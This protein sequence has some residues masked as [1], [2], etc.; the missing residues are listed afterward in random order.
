M[1]D[2]TRL[3][4]FLSRLWVQDVHEPPVNETW[5]EMIARIRGGGNQRVSRETY[6]YFL[7]VLPPHYYGGDYFAFCEGAEA[8]KLFARRGSAFVAR[9]LT[10]QETV[11]F[12]DL[13]GI[14]LP[15]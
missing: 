15:D 10:W 4:E 2:E 1:R 3:N 8:L 14:D 5:R 9:Q 6:L 7:E 12:C 13:A 11:T